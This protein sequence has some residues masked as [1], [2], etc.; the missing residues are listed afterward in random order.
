[1]DRTSILLVFNH[2]LN[3]VGAS[4]IVADRTGTKVRGDG[5]GSSPVLRDGS[6]H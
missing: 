5:V 2:A 4:Y 3:L 1:M 6:Q